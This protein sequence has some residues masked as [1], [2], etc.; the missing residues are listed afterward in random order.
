MCC[1]HKHTNYVVFAIQFSGFLEIRKVILPKSSHL[2]WSSR[3]GTTQ[4]KLHMQR[5]KKHRSA[6]ITPKVQ[7]A[8]GADCFAPRR[9][10]RSSADRNGN[11]RI[12]SAEESKCDSL[13][14]YNKCVY[15]NYIYSAAARARRAIIIGKS[16]G[17]ASLWLIMLL[18]CVFA[19]LT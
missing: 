19:A 18:E 10:T 11:L 1:L 16:S 8:V 14:L 5:S 2:I 9:W 3:D 15:G 13:A 4:K 6:I 7:A 12:S 17:S